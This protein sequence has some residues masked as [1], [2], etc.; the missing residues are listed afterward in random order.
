MTKKYLLSGM[1]GVLVILIGVSV[2]Y[3]TAV[4]A[5]KGKN[6][7]VT[8]KELKIEYIDS[9]EITATN[10]EPGWNTTKTFSVENKAESTYL[11]NIVIKDLV[12]TFKT[13][14][15][16][17]YKIESTNSGYNT[18]NEWIDIPKVLAATDTVI[19]NKISI[20]VNVKQEYTIYLRYQESGENQ[21]I[22]QGKTFSGKIEIEEG[23][24]P[25]LLSKLLEINTTRLTRA[26]FNSYLTTDNTGTLYTTQNTEDGSLVYYFAG[27]ALNNWVKFGKCTSSDYNCT[28]GDDLY[29]RIIRTNTVLADGGKERNCKGCIRNTAFS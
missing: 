10:I 21:N 6:V 28:V 7:L 8:S 26:S 17:Q 27:N 3:F 24:N 4:I 1:I 23:T 29:W 9:S 13:Y 20:P 15:N 2:A 16:L 18:N 19:A 25:T 12:N 22:D 14:G 5:G 11:Y